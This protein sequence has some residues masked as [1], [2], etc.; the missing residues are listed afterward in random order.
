M[1]HKT[2]SVAVA[3]KHLIDPILCS[4]LCTASSPGRE[5]SWRTLY[6]S[7][8]HVLCHFV[9]CY[10]GN[11]MMASSPWSHA[12]GT[13]FIIIAA[14]TQSIITSSQKHHEYP[15]DFGAKVSSVIH[16]VI[17]SR[18]VN[19][20]GQIVF[21]NDSESVEFRIL[22]IY[23]PF[24]VDAR[25][26]D[27]K[28]VQSLILFWPFQHHSVFYTTSYHLTSTDSSSSGHLSRPA[29]I[30]KSK[31]TSKPKAKMSTRYVATEP[32]NG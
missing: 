13:R 4:T 25:E 16:L 29:T 23:N 6:P 31:D 3:S 24:L 10:E 14:T 17:C 21:P 1:N 22:L 8:S 9:V 19:S 18:T 12:Q 15:L 5:Y 32:V 27:S 26:Q 7:H 28:D 2:F 20:D 11:G 30:S